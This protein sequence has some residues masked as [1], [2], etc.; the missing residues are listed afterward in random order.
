MKLPLKNYK[1]TNEYNE[2]HQLRIIN[3]QGIVETKERPIQVCS[4]VLL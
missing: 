4:N 2:P 3:V 1:R